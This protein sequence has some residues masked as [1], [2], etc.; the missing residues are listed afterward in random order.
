INCSLRN[1]IHQSIGQ[2]P[3]LVVFGQHM[4]TNG[5]DY[6]VLRNLRL[7]EDNTA[8]L[9]RHDEFDKIRSNIH[10]HMEKTYDQN[11]RKQHDRNERTYNLRSRIKSFRPGQ[12]VFRRNFQQSCFVKGFNAKLAPIF[13][14]VRVRRKLGQAFYELEDLQGNLAGKFHAKDIKQ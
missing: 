10:R 12:E 13:V 4:I 3:Y 8:Q 1:S 11:K 7:L 9:S 2:S 14:K 5:K 6:Q